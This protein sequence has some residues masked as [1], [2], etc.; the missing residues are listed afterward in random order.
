MIAQDAGFSVAEGDPG[1]ISQ[2]A[3]WHQELADAF[4]LHQATISG[5]ASSVLTTWNGEAARS[6]GDLSSVVA[7]HFG[8]AAALSRTAAETL[9]RYA[10]ELERCQREG[11]T[12]LRQTEYWLAEQN[13]WQGKLT[14]ADRAVSAAQ[15]QISAA[16]STLSNPL[17]TGLFSGVTQ[18]AAHSQLTTGEAAL[19]QAQ[20]AQRT[21]R[22]E[23]EHAEQ[24]ALL[25]QG[26]G[27]RA[28]EE[29]MSAAQQ[30]TGSVETIQI[31]P[32]PLAGWA[33]PDRFNTPA[34]ARHGGGGG[35][36]SDPLG[37]LGHL[38]S[39]GWDDL[40]DGLGWAGHH[41]ADALE[42]A[43]KLALEGTGMV[44]STTVPGLILRGVSS[45]TGKTIG[46][47]GGGDVTDG[48]N[49]SGSLCYDATPDGGSGFTATVGGGLGGPPGIGASVGPVV[50]NGQT[51]SDQGG[52]FTYGG[53][54]AGAELASGGANVSV[55][56]NSHHKLIWDVNPGWTPNIG[57]A[58]VSIHAG[59]SRTW[60]YPSFAP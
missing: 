24:Q 35:F 28:W 25:W 60:T 56:H 19:S 13:L 29:A 14:D 8:S 41:A 21:A 7:G 48:W 1:Q 46:I 39:G 11:A 50:S 49:A 53:G 55:G 37:T 45:L 43:P 40:R 57:V 58:P 4:E 15:T 51:L 44:I 38:A 42:Q 33:V 54:S 22:R 23:L 10:T 36:F 16:R 2:A 27:R 12:A 52:P 34:P 59:E 9:T 5:A 26:R 47:C 30:A 3:A 18:S 20:S 31:T 17:M 6:Y 32:P